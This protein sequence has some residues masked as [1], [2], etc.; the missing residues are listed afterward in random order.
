MP[1]TLIEHRG[2]K[3]LNADERA[4][5]LA[6]VRRDPRPAVQSFALTLSHACGI[7]AVA[8]GVPLPTIAAALGHAPLTT[9]AVGA[10]HRALVARMWA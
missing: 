8:A 9:T 7:A 3:Y 1:L 5:F 4:R 6:S 10:G 2:R